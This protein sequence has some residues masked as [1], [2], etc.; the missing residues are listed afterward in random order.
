MSLPVN[1]LERHP[2]VRGGSSACAWKSVLVPL[3]ASAGSTWVLARA[4]RI[5]EQPGTSVTLL[6]VIECTEAQANDAHFRA[7]SRHREARKSLAGVRTNLLAPSV[8]SRAQL[9]FGDPA[10]EILHEVSEGGHDLVVM[11]TRGR[12]SLR[13]LLL[14]SVAERV[15]QA[16]PT[17]LL[18]VRPMMGR[19]EPMSS[20]ETCEAARFQ[21]LLIVLDGLEPGEEILPMAEGFAR[22]FDSKVCLFGA[23]TGVSKESDRRR[24]AEEYLATLGRSLA[25]RGLLS[26]LHICTGSVADEAL[27]LIH[28]HEFDSVALM[29][30]GSF[31]RSRAIR[32]TVAQRLVRES[33]VPV[34]VMRNRRLRPEISAPAPEHRQAWV[35]LT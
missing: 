4:R 22:A 19:D 32:G 15:L 12:M 14:G 23:I 25:T 3:D 21:H 6:R 24:R 27:A 29:T 7:D 9:R 30:Q 8:P 16:S 2:E 10:T 17:P 5:L 28:K 26:R 34:L 35:T 13:R 33:G 20:V 1:E 11:S 31:G 18:L